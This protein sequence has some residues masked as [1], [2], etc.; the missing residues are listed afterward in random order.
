[1]ERINGKCNGVDPVMQ[2]KLVQ[3]LEEHGVYSH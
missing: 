1:L 2:D 3:L